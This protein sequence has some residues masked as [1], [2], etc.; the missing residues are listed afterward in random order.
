MIDIRNAYYQTWALGRQHKE[1]A[2]DFDRYILLRA[3]YRL[4]SAFYPAVRPLAPERVSH[5]LSIVENKGQILQL[6]VIDFRHHLEACHTDQER[7]LVIN[8]YLSKCIWKIRLQKFAPKFFWALFVV[9]LGLL[10]TY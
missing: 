8:T 2:R 7:F 10:L 3:L 4:Q 5:L 6:P 1:T 9:T